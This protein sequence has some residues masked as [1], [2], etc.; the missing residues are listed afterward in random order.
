MVVPRTRATGPAETRQPARPPAERTSRS[1]RRAPARPAPARPA[2]TSTNGSP[3][4]NPTKPPK[5]RTTAPVSLIEQGAAG[6]LASVRRHDPQADVA[7]IERAIEF[8]ID[9][10][11]DQRRAS[12]EPYVT[13]PIAAAQILADIDIDP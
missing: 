9:A 5:P 3:P 1:A 12:G 13:H 11:G 4:A 10:H 7:A 2:S 8:A 6:L